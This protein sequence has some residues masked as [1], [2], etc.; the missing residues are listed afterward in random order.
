MMNKDTKPSQT[1]STLDLEV[2]LHIVFAGRTTI[3]WALLATVV[4]TALLSIGAPRQYESSVKLM[5][6]PRQAN[7]RFQAEIRT[8]QDRRAF[9]E[10]IKE[11]LVSKTVLMRTLA[12]LEK[13]PVDTV[14]PSD[15]DELTER[16]ALQ[17]RSSIARSLIGGD[18]IGEANTFFLTVRHNNPRRAAEIANEVVEQFMTFSTELR[19]QQT[20]S[21]TTAL[22]AAVEDSTRQVKEAHN[23]LVAFETEVGPL[24]PELMN[25]DKASI[26]VFPELEKLREEYEKAEVELAEREARAEA[27]REAMAD[28]ADGEFPAIP[29]HAF[30]AVPA[31]RTLSDRM[32]ELTIKA[33][34][35]LPYY[36]EESREVTSL[37]EEMA[38]TRGEVLSQLQLLDAAERQAMRTMKAT[39]EARERSLKGYEERLSELS[40]QNST[41]QELKRDYE[42]KARTLDSQLQA[43]AEAESMAAEK[44]G[45]HANI[46]VIDRAV[47]ADTPVSPRPLRNIALSLVVGLLLGILALTANHYTRPL[48][49]HPRQVEQLTGLPIVGIL[50]EENV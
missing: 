16:I 50:N 10:T 47:P 7:T 2:L 12:A 46:T 31:L 36:L 32:T 3:L 26:R 35:L 34:A 6:E 43:L 27:F 5:A 18:G 17:T 24:L 19:Q 20:R 11:L 13:R 40:R 23:R 38:L 33:N 9:I 28:L 45:A 21:A 29:E 42:A 25:I 39:Q 44:Y 8:N 37:R 1:T 41:Y 14:M 30:L 49:V 48:F 4:A 15:V 22:R